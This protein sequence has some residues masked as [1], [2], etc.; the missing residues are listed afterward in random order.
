MKT[1]IRC[2]RCGRPCGHF[3]PDQD[4]PPVLYTWAWQRGTRDNMKYYCCQA[5]FEGR[6]KRG[7]VDKEGED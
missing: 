3:Y 4:I 5:H 7:E 2:E 1:Y 6:E